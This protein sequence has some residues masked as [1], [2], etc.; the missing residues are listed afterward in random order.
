MNLQQIRAYA[1]KC[2]IP[3]IKPTT[4][5]ILIEQLKYSKPVNV[6]EI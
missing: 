2:K 6:V 4:E 1:E 3:I 5:Q